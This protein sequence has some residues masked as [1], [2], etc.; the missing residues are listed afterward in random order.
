MVM[1]CNKNARKLLS[2]YVG[3]LDDENRSAFNSQGFLPIHLPENDQSSLSFTNRK[4]KSNQ[5]SSISLHE[6]IIMQL[7]EPN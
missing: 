3:K 6:L 5:D 2:N 4:D 1:F 7:D